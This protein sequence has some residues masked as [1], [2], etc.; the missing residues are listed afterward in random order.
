MTTSAMPLRWPNKP[1]RCTINLPNQVVAKLTPVQPSCPPPLH[2]LAL[3]KATARA[4]G[5]GAA[6]S[7][8][9]KRGAVGTKG[10]GAAVKDTSKTTK[11]NLT[12]YFDGCELT[13]I[14]REWHDQFGAIAYDVVDTLEKCTN[15]PRYRCQEGWPPELLNSVAKSLVDLFVVLAHAGEEIGVKTYKATR[16]LTHRRVAAQKKFA[17]TTQNRMNHN[18]PTTNT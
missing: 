6:S 18:N 1:P 4:S 5:G 3:A 2:L 14:R 16:R 12:E 11:I 10:K 9:A 15:L 17:G 13:I 7:C 8:G